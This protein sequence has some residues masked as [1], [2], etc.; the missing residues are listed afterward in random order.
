MDINK[1]IMD[2]NAGANE[3]E[4]KALSKPWNMAMASVAIVP[5]DQLGIMRNWINSMPTNKDMPNNEQVR[6]E[7]VL[8]GDAKAAMPKMTHFLGTNKLNTG[9]V[10]QFAR[11]I[12]SLKAAKASLWVEYL[13]GGLD[14]GGTLHIN[15]AVE[16]V[17]KA[18][19]YADTFPLDIEDPEGLG[20]VTSLSFSMGNSGNHNRLTLGLEGDDLEDKMSLALELFEE[21]GVPELSD[22]MARIL[23]AEQG[24]LS[25]VIWWN[26]KGLLRLGVL[27]NQ[28][29]NDQVLRAT[30]A[31]NLEND[32]VRA[33]FEGGLQVKQ[34]SAILVYFSPQG[35]GIDYHY[36]YQ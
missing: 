17:I 29:T 26:E 2:A 19:T 32:Q 33:A 21:M 30:I 13:G 27:L 5:A 10:G 20:M 15:Q 24:D 9:M 31:A 7:A 3:E 16:E 18:T 35:L 12:N 6:L 1:I 22:E 8:G 36:N 23:T 34:P 14:L 25:L 4:I 11:G 28:P